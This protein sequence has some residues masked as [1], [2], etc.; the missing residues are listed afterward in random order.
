MTA[1]AGRRARS[2]IGG[3]TLRYKIGAGGMSEVWYAE[4]EG[5]GGAIKPCVIKIILPH[6][7]DNEK[8]VRRFLEEG[9]L[10]SQL[11]HPNVVAVSDFG[12]ERGM[13]FLVLEH[14][15][16]L[17]LGRLRAQLAEHAASHPPPAPSPEMPAWERELCEWHPYLLRGVFPPVFVA[18][19]G[20]KAATALEYI[21]KT[22]IRDGDRTIVGL[23]H[24]DISDCNIMLDRVGRLVVMDLG[25]AKAMSDGQKASATGTAWGKLAYSP[26]EPLAGQEI[27]PSAD[28]YALGITL[29]ILLAGRHPFCDPKLPHEHPL[30]R[31]VRMARDERPPIREL[32]PDVPV[33]LADVLEGLIQ[34]KAERRAPRDAAALADRLHEIIDELGS[35]LLRLEKQAA[36]LVQRVDVDRAK[37]GTL[38][39]PIPPAPL[40]ARTAPLDASHERPVAHA[41]PPVPSAER[42]PDTLVDHT[43]PVRDLADD[44]SRRTKLR[45]SIAAA[46][47]VLAALGG[48]AFGLFVLPAL[49][50]SKAT[51]DGIATAETVFALACGLAATLAVVIA[52]ERGIPAL[53]FLGAAVVIAHPEARRLPREDRRRALIGVAGLAA[54]VAALFLLR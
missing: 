35:D 14:V 19:I 44:A 42:V 50:A 11:S 53:P 20:M 28:L 15:R 3:Y 16:G 22:E 54:V 25:I 13:Y 1:A 40:P 38:E 48:T 4:K 49:I 26:A 46:T 10:S 29:F 36:A 2:T 23:V 51:S 24:R 17:D 6:L 47:I 9:R 43:S 21:H 41:V 31:A 18:W 7:S 39:D 33:A 8:R 34:A 45:R 5:P 37:D 32:L 27:D 30:N 52:A 12:V